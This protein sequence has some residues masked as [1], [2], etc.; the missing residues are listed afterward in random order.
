MNWREKTWESLAKEVDKLE[1]VTG[2]WTDWEGCK[3]L[4]IK[5]FVPTAQHRVAL[6]FFLN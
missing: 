2:W 5:A 3:S 6:T 4:G 1:D